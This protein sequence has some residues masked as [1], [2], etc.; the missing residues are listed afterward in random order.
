VI[1]YVGEVA[2]R[3]EQFWCPI[4]HALKTKA[5]HRRY[6]NFAVYGDAESYHIKLQEL[7]EDLRHLESLEA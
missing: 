7:R 2:S 5:K 3:T 1:S 6:H 4:R